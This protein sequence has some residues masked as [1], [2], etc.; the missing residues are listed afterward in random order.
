MLNPS[1][2]KRS[3]DKFVGKVKKKYVV[4]TFSTLMALS[5]VIPRDIYAVSG[6]T[7]VSFMDVA[8][9]ARALV[10]NS[11]NV[12]GDGSV[13]YDLSNKSKDEMNKKFRDLIKKIENEVNRD[14][15]NQDWGRTEYLLGLMHDILRGVGND[16]M[17]REVS[18]LRV[19]VH[20]DFVSHV[21]LTRL[22]VY[23]LKGS[24]KVYVIS[25]GRSRDVGTALSVSLQ[26]AQS[27]LLRYLKINS[28]VAK[29]FG[30]IVSTNFREGEGI[31]ELI[32]FFQGGEI[33][34]DDGTVLA[35]KEIAGRLESE[36]RFLPLK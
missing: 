18:N 7:L 12:S 15:K 14:I 27:S 2:I 3:F 6:E 13:S 28:A 21:D 9:S 30:N 16:D 24:G 11:R 25:Y 19:K 10:D 22:G 33:V 34:L 32:T 4:I 26:D 1:E 5:S 36:Q 8:K 20:E 23:T 17:A 29:K 31:Y 35:E